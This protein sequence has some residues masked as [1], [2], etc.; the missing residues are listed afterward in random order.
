MRALKNTL[1]SHCSRTLFFAIVAAGLIGASN[2]QAI[3][4]GSWNGHQDQT[5]SFGSNL[6][7]Q[8]FSGHSST[9]TSHTSSGGSQ[10]SLLFS[11]GNFDLSGFASS[12]RE[13]IRNHPGTEY[14]ADDWQ[15]DRPGGSNPVPEPTAALL[16]AAGLGVVVSRRRIGFN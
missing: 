12:A 2:A 11:F 3:Q 6:L 7:S 5:S 1:L 16:F 15:H 13:W 14:C 10:P 8:L 9:T 4:A